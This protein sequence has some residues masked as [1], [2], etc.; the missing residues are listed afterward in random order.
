MHY[1]FVVKEKREIMLCDD[2]DDDVFV[3][4]I[5]FFSSFSWMDWLTELWLQS[6]LNSWEQ[7][8]KTSIIS[9]C[10]SFFENRKKYSYPAYNIF[11]C[12]HHRHSE[13]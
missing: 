11:V 3:F 2:N 9:L 4:L 13:T 8:K 1:L 6:C 5:F 7:K 10:P 12:L